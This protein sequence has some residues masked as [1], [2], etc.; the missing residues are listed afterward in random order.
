MK[1]IRRSLKVSKNLKQLDEIGVAFEADIAKEDLKEILAE[2][3]DDLIETITGFVPGLSVFI[4]L[5]KAYKSIKDYF[6]ISKI[7][8]FLT[9]ISSMSSVE[10]NTLIG[11]I[12]EDPIYEQKFGTF[13][14]TALDRLDFVDK[15]SY[16][17][18]ICK[19]Y[20]KGQISK[21]QL[22]RFKGFIE[23]IELEDL[24]KC[25]Y[26]YEGNGPYYSFPSEFR[27]PP[28]FMFQ[29][30]G[31]V[32]ITHYEDDFNDFRVLES[33]GLGRDTTSPQK[34]TLTDLGEIFIAVINDGPLT[35]WYISTNK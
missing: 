12:N 13:L 35:E 17:A 28:L 18:R 24:K 34:P 27:D 9:D 16:L 19:F 8:R 4:K 2:Q 3:T 25:S 20:G 15:A 29:A 30:L 33:A 31:I 21:S 22:I 6:L 11:K 1:D 5:R 14:I 23:K 26:L 7:F 32:K 10:R